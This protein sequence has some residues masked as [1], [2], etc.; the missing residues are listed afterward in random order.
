MSSPSGVWGRAPTAS[1]FFIH[2]DKTRA[3]IWPP[4]RKH[5]AA[6]MSKSGQIWD[7]NP[8]TGQ[9]GVLGEL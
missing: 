2:T 1:N 4:M 8:K 5:T 3:I 6:E 7:T 9:M